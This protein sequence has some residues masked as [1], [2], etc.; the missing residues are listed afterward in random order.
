MEEVIYN[1]RTM[2][3][4]YAWSQRGASYFPTT[5]GSAE[6]REYKY[7]EIFEDD[8]GDTTHKEINR[9]S[10]CHFLCKVLKK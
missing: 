4:S 2:E 6:T 7:L 1:V 5:C 9:P 10:I 3:I 8:F